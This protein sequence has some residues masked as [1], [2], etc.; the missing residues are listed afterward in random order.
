[1]EW[2]PLVDVTLLV[3]IAWWLWEIRRALGLRARPRSRF[4]KKATPSLRR[5]DFKGAVP[6]N[7]FVVIRWPDALFLYQGTG[8]AAAREAYARNHPSIGEEIEFWE[9]T[10]CRGHK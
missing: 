1:M 6:P 8:G 3:P 7:R 5:A 9:N 10:E 2:L 4:A